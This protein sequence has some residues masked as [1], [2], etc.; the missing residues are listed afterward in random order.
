MAQSVGY[1]NCIFIEP[2]HVKT[3]A[4]KTVNIQYREKGP[5]CDEIDFNDVINQNHW[6]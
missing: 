1:L 2:Y 6:R 3:E 5:R 4:A